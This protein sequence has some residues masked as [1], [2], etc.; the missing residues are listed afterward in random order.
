MHRQGD[1][2]ARHR[3][4][5]PAVLDHALGEGR[6]GWEAEQLLEPIH[7][8]QVGHVDAEQG[9]TRP[10]GLDEVV[11]AFREVEQEQL[12]GAICCAGEHRNLA[13]RLAVT[14]ARMECGL[15]GSE[16]F[17]LGGHEQIRSACGHGVAR[18]HGDRVWID[19]RRARRGP[20]QCR[21]A[22]AHP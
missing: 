16:P 13:E 12:K 6:V 4:D 5:I 19:V 8:G 21:E 10:V 22:V 20:E 7:V 17:Q 18:G 11:G 15:C 14:L 3:G 2:G 1:H 9:G